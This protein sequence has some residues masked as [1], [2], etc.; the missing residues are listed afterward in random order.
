MKETDLISD[1]M[2]EQ[3]RTLHD[4]PHFGRGSGKAF[5]RVRDI[6]ENYDCKTVL[7]Y[8]CGKAKLFKKFEGGKYDIEWQ[9]YDPAVA[10]YCKMPKPADLVIVR[11]VMEHVEIEKID[12]VLEHIASLS[13]NV[14]W[15]LIPSGKSSKSLPDGRN[16]HLTREPGQWWA[17][18]IGKYFTFEGTAKANAF[19]KVC[20]PIE[21]EK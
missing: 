7:D 15:F 13:N 17:E 19:Q 3:N 11:D 6:I 9:N 1:Y 12:N 5:G 18:R 16:A 20:Q 4:D 8:G 2:R 14:V 21:K 10:M